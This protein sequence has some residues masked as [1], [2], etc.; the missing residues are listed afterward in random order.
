MFFSSPLYGRSCFDMFLDDVATQSL[1]PFPLHMCS[2]SFSGCE[3]V[4]GAFSLLG[5][6]PFLFFLLLG[7]CLVLR[8]VLCSPF[9][10]EL[11]TLAVCC[12]AGGFDR[13]IYLSCARCV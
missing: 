3:E 11:G 12:V 2:S 5:G 4:G 13:T 1:V 6:A 9:Q 10:V 7:F 8:C